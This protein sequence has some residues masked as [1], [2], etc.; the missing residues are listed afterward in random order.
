[1]TRRPW[2]IL[3]AIA[4]LALSAAAA[5][6]EPYVPILLGE[7]Q[8]DPK[9]K[10]P[11]AVQQARVATAS[12]TYGSTISPD[13][14][15]YVVQFQG[16]VRTTWK[17]QAARIGAE[18]LDYVPRYAFT[19]RM[20][21]TAASQV[22]A[23]P[24]VRWVGPFPAKWKY[25]QRLVADPKRAFTVTA[26]LFRGET[27]DNVAR[28]VAD[29]K[30]RCQA[31]TWR[32]QPML[33]LRMAAAAIPELAAL[34]EVAWIG[35]YKR[36][37]LCNSMGQRYLGVSNVAGLPAPWAQVDVWQ[38]YGLFGASQ[39]VGI[40]DTGLD[41]GDLTDLHHD[42]LD[43]SGQP[44]VVQAFALGRENDWSDSTEPPVHYGGHGT[45]VAGSV[46]GNGAQSGGNAATS[47]YTGSFA[48][49][50]PEAGLV[51]QSVMDAYGYLSGIPDDFSQLFEQA[52][53]AGASIH[54]NSWGADYDLGYYS[55]EAAVVDDYLWR[56]PD[57]TILYAAGNAGV[58]WDA[59]GVIDPTSIG[60][61]AT[62]KNC[63][64]VGATESYRP[65]G[66][67]WGGIANY[68]W[69]YA[70]PYDYPVNPIASDY[71]SNNP[72]GMAAFSSRGPC[73]DGRI[74]PDVVAP[75][76]NIISCRS[77]GKYGDYRGV[78]ELW[79][80]YDNWYLYSGGTSMA[81]PLAAGAAALV[82]DYYATVRGH[83]TPSGALV[84]ATLINGAIDLAP[85]QYG[86]GAKQEIQPR[87]DRSQGWGRPAV[88]ATLYPAVAH[89]GVELIFHDDG[90]ITDT[91]KVDAY[92]ATVAGS[93]APLAMTLV[94][95]D[96]PAAPYV[97]TAL[98]NDLDLTVITPTGRRYRG[99]FGTTAA[100]DRVNNVERVEIPTP[101]SGSYSIQ[102]S[103][104]NLPQ[105]P[106]PYALVMSAVTT[107][108]TTYSISGSV[109]DSKGNPIANVA[110]TAQGIDTTPPRQATAL[111][112]GDGT[113]RIA[114]LLPADYRVTASKE[115]YQFAPAEQT[116]SVTNAD[117]TGVDFVATA[118]APVVI[119][120]IG[121]RVTDSLGRGVPNIAVGL[122]TENYE[123][124]AQTLT[125]GTGTYW[126][127]NLEPGT[128]YVVATPIA[129]YYAIPWYRTIVLPSPES[130][131]QNFRLLLFFYGSIDIY[132]MT[133]SKAP[134]YAA[135]VVLERSP[136]GDTWTVAQRRQTNS[137][138]FARLGG[139]DAA[140][141][142]ILRDQY[143]YR[144]SLR[145]TGYTFQL[146]PVV[147]H[148]EGWLPPGLW[149]PV[150]TIANNPVLFFWGAYGTPKYA[151]S[152]LIRT[153]W[154]RPVSDVKVTYEGL[155]TGAVF[156]ARTRADGFYQIATMPADIYTVAVEKADWVFAPVDPQFGWLDPYYEPWVKVGPPA[157][158]WY[159]ELAFNEPEDCW[160]DGFWFRN[161]DGF[162]SV[163]YPNGRQD[164]WGAPRSLLQ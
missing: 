89:P 28:F 72:S 55:Y 76:T 114:E 105:A 35:E 107:A 140:G 122:F 152:G 34:P 135:T 86:T 156:H 119:S 21:A 90:V 115:G 74:K 38:D 68:T 12:A 71:I 40:A 102:V 84:K 117:V 29:R 24:F 8:F 48:G 2:R 160:N 47:S 87:P 25:R 112:G 159:P 146:T 53:T 30:L 58:D 148:A 134:I 5:P 7:T 60:Q 132:A 42:F 43:A 17:R 65:P 109:A 27:F 147:D 153:L 149:T 77:R 137:Q 52:R 133:P 13:R 150:G 164:Y 9:C 67:G 155:S 143:R 124:I 45:H 91:G 130:A 127:R 144:V 116:A 56:H 93:T 110:I 108:V 82:R 83:A 37:Q 113:Y 49:M 4:L 95:T 96:A 20:T 70:W 79:G 22:A 88:G 151:A 66:H 23:L 69:G 61:P 125:D 163:Q 157:Y 80:I 31:F 75:G 11:A 100:Y 78:E 126:F 63:I 161:V 41:T 46:L 158:L 104:F 33:R 51:F 3:G 120:T 85:G 32:P 99:N 106:Q 57:M 103:G 44:R 59:N 94:W 98:V 92:S 81:T 73:V 1:M 39:I 62:A 138:G 6:A 118:I 128:Y 54:T 145:K 123:L 64:T 19:T 26:T 50:A 10:E 136:D 154:D 101:A 111:T 162:M 139:L 16:P 36:P 14:G 18:L 141:Q 142:Q 97:S 121:G 129:N 15:Y 131:M